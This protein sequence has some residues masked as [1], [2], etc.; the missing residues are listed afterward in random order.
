M[1]GVIDQLLGYADPNVIVAGIIVAIMG[2]F[3]MTRINIM[4]RDKSSDRT[5]PTWHWGF[6]WRDTLP[7]IIGSFLTNVAVI[8]LFIRFSNDFFGFPV[9]MFIC[10]LIGMSVD[11]LT[12]RL[13][14]WSK[15]A[16]TILAGPAANTNNSN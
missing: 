5:P 8:I 16:R 7:R 6:F 14:E 3:I 2:M 12:I 11:W 4:N 1:N 13:K 10:L 15:R 9:T